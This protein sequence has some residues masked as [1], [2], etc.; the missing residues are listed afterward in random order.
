MPTTMEIGHLYELNAADCRKEAKRFHSRAEK[1]GAFDL[2]FVYLASALAGLAAI[3]AL[4]TAPTWI[5]AASAGA[6]AIIAGLV[7]NLNPA[8]KKSVRLRLYGQWDRLASCYQEAKIRSEEAGHDVFEAE[9]A[10]EAQQALA[11]IKETL[12]EEK[13]VVGEEEWSKARV[14][15]R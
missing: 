7:G 15:V 4:V 2:A 8:E 11:A 12:A 6:S 13:P 9:D 10:R 5:T 14:P 1:W 3:T